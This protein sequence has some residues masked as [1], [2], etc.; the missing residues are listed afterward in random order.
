MSPHPSR[1]RP[2]YPPQPPTPYPGPD[3]APGHGVRFE[4]SCFCLKIQAGLSLT[5]WYVHIYFW[6]RPLGTHGNNR[7]GMTD[8]APAKQTRAALCLWRRKSGPAEG[9][10][11]ELCTHPSLSPQ[12]PLSPSASSDQEHVPG[13]PCSVLGPH[14]PCTPHTPRE[15]GQHPWVDSLLTCHP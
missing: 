8:Q 1:R 14:A 2:H 4:I 12:A 10:T 11:K 15:A 7:L 6:T 9:T 5:M 3:A 13:F